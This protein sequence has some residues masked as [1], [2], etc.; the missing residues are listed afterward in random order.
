MQRAGQLSRVLNPV[1]TPISHPS[2]PAKAAPGQLSLKEINQCLSL[3]GSIDPL[4]FYLLGNP[5]AH[6]RSPALHNSLFKEIGLP[7]RYFLQETLDAESAIAVATDTDFGGASV[8][9]PYKETIIQFLDELTEE[10]TE[11][12]AVNTIIPVTRNG[13]RYLIGDN[14]DWIGIQSSFTSRDT[15]GT[16][17]RFPGLVIGNGGTA[18]SAIYSL[19]KM[20]VNPIYV[21][22]RSPDK[23]QSM[24]KYGI[25][26]ISSER[27]ARQIPEGPAYAISTIPGNVTIDTTLT[28]IISTILSAPS[29][30]V[31]RQFLEMAYLPLETDTMR[32]AKHYQ[33][34]TI[35]GAAP[36]THQGLRQF[37]LWTGFKVPTRFGL[38]AVGVDEESLSVNSV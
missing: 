28:T 30:T 19:S 2:L 33:W 22:C 32:L 15:R 13:R 3:I 8:T 7:H 18:K 24:T 11:M 17:R 12:G 14:T 21:A 9:I 20:G 4:R 38:R 37:E 36:L 29:S 5:I 31:E 25:V 26:L 16:G 34:E 10:A 23:L 1:L 6:S 27:E 35:P